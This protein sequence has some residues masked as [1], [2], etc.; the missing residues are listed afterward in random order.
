MKTTYK[1]ALILAL[2]G[3][4]SACGKVGNVQP[5]KGEKAVQNTYPAPSCLDKIKDIRNA[6]QCP[7]P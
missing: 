7:K 5:P 1:L 3:G 6:H 4:I 2:T